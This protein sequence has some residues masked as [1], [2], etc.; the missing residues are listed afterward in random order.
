VR[1]LAAFVTAAN[2]SEAERGAAV[3]SL[4]WATRSRD[5]FARFDAAGALGD[6]AQ[7]ES[8]R[9]LVRTADVRAALKAIANDDA[10]PRRGGVSTAWSVGEN[11]RRAL[12]HVGRLGGFPWSS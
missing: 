8:A 5:A 7:E 1:N 9:S 12:R 11:A 2:A 6:L 10:M 4:V 3:A